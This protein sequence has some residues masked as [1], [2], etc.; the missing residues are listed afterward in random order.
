MSTLVGKS[1]VAGVDLNK[2]RMRAVLEAVIALAPLP[3]GFTISQLAA[4]VREILDL[5][6][7]DYLPRHAAYDLKK[8]RG[9]EWVQKM[10]KSRRY[11]TAPHGLQLM[12]ALLLLRDKVIKP[13]LAGAGKP[14]RG[15]RPQQESDVDKHYRLIQG[16]MRS[17]LHLLNVAV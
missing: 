4:K 14:K 12:T 11:Q 1:K 6:A 10:G 5:S 16:E 17:L 13:V 7:T 9:K 2:P 15:P 3:T 8:L